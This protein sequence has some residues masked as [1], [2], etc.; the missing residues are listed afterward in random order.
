MTLLHSIQRS[1]FE[2]D[3]VHHGKS[4]TPVGKAAKPQFLPG[5]FSAWRR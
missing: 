5:S 3:V 1:D 4:M 2:H